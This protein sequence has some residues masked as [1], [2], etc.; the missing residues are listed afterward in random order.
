[1]YPENYQ[2]L[3]KKAYNQILATSDSFFKDFKGFE[4][5]NLT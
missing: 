4:D 3:P 5:F 2:S 1:M